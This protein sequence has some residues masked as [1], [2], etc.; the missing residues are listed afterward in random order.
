MV[1][2]RQRGRQPATQAEEGIGSTKGPESCDTRQPNGSGMGTPTCVG[3]RFLSFAHPALRSRLRPRRRPVLTSPAM[4]C[5]R[6]RTAGSPPMP[7]RSIS[8]RFMT[9]S[10]P[11]AAILTPETSA[12]ISFRRISARPARGLG[13]RP[14][15]PGLTI[16]RDRYGIPHL[17][18]KT[19]GVDVRLGLGHSRGPLTAASARTGGPAR[20]AVADV[21]G[22]NAFSLVT[23]RPLVR[24]QS[25]LRASRHPRAKAAGQDLRAQGSTDR[26]RR[27]ELR[28]RSNCLLAQ[29]RRQPTALDRK[30]RDCG[31]RVHRL[32]LRRR[33]RR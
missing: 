21:P 31:D 9:V 18:G 4:C 23:E 1:A 14:G 15:E 8:S 5:R 20:A 27:E 10:L 12:A 3:L 32:D 16:I 7:I 2:G 33:R 25:R 24:A 13:N 26:P 22:I 29:G 11:C 17:R 6:A 28:A 30:R 19:L